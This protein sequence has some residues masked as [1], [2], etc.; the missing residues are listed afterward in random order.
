MTSPSAPA[1]RTKRS[2]WWLE[3]LLVVW[4]AWVY[5]AITNLAPLRVHAALAHARGVLP[6]RAVAGDRAG[7]LAR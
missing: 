6:G 7:A 5:D 1:R 4:L 3:T 2:R